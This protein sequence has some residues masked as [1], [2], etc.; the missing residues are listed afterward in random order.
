ML[1]FRTVTYCTEN[2]ETPRGTNGARGVAAAQRQH[3]PAP[4]H[5]HGRRRQ[6]VAG[7]VEDVLQVVLVAKARHDI[8]DDSA[9]LGGRQPDRTADAA[10]H[11][12]E[13]GD[14][15]GAN[16]VVHVGLEEMQRQASGIGAS[17]AVARVQRGMR[18]RRLGK[19]LDRDADAGLA[20]DQHN[21]AR[22]QAGHQLGR[23]GRGR[24]AVRV[25]ALAQVLAQARAQPSPKGETPCVKRGQ[26]H[27]RLL[28]RQAQTCL[29]PER[30]ARPH[31]GYTIIKHSLVTRSP[32][33]TN[34]K[35]LAH[36]V[37]CQPACNQ[38]SK[39]RPEAGGK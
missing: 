31:I 25:N 34:S 20:F 35:S 2:E 37:S 16:P 5:R 8:V 27:S 33:L 19:V 29:L 36:E 11:P 3:A 21:V 10:V 15:D 7:Q 9:D 6:Q 13:R 30:R 32:L 1:A 28:S 38:K 23:V 14:A 22:P 39:Q 17:H 18:P 12:L 24:R 26:S 4:A